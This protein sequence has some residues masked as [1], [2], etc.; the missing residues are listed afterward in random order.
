MEYQYGYDMELGLKNESTLLSADSDDIIISI[1]N[2]LYE[3]K[4]KKK[5]HKQMTIK[6]WCTRL[7]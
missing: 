5:T 7:N 2:K 4:R 1:G 6:V 3:K